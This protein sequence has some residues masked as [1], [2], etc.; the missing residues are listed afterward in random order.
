[1]LSSNSSISAGDNN[2]TY[3][4]A[5]IPTSMSTCVNC[6]ELKS[7][8]EIFI[9]WCMAGLPNRAHIF[10]IPLHGVQ[11]SSFKIFIGNAVWIAFWGFPGFSCLVRPC[12]QP[13]MS[14]VTL[15]T[16]CISNR[17]CS[18]GNHSTSKATWCVWP[19]WHLWKTWLLKVGCYRLAR[20]CW[21]VMFE[22]FP[23]GP[24]K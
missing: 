13:Y 20:W 16:K 8:L 11:L 3:S 18:A 6:F 1:M 4:Q 19:L 9:P 5:N 7:Q 22:S 12:P 15:N 24:N 17:R 21:T 14:T 23:L 10:L 2:S